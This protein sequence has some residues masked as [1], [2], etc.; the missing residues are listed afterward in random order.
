MPLAVPSGMRRTGVRRTTGITGPG[1]AGLAASLGDMTLLSLDPY[2]PDPDAV[3][4]R[5]GW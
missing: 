4:H 1:G 2:Q 5:D 3:I